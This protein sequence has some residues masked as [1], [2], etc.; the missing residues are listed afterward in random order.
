MELPELKVA[1][2]LFFSG[3]VCA[4]CDRPCLH[5][6]EGGLPSPGAYV[7]STVD[8]RENLAAPVCDACVS[9]FTPNS[10]PRSRP[11]DSLDALGRAAPAGLFAGVAA[12][13]ERD[14]VRRVICAAFCARDDVMGG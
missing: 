3:E 7:A 5:E 13:A 4:I 2:V 10:S 12:G 9:G 14:E 6:T 1:T 8:D 11:S